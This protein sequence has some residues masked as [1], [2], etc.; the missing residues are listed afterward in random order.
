MCAHRRTG[1]G[2]PPVYSHGQDDRATSKSV[3]SLP[4][5]RARATSARGRWIRHLPRSQS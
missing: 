1:T 4:L 5:A 2:V 3:T